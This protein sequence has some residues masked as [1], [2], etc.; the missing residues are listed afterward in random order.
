MANGVKHHD[1]DDDDANDTA[2]EMQVVKPNAALQSSSSSTTALTSTS[3]SSSS[4]STSTSTS[5]TATSTTNEPHLGDPTLG[6]D[7]SLF[8]AKFRSMAERARPLILALVNILR[9]LACYVGVPF[10]RFFQIPVFCVPPNTFLGTTSVTQGMRTV[11]RRLLVRRSI[12]GYVSPQ[13]SDM[14]SIRFIGNSAAYYD[15]RASLLRTCD[16]F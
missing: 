9:R 15:E 16:S 5:S 12:C 11:A 8:Y 4:T 2:S 7:A 6:G 1:D 3:P 14:F 13:K 10:L